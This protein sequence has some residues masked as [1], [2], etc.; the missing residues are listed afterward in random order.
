MAR[1]GLWS[2]IVASQGQLLRPEATQKKKQIARRTI[3][4]LVH[5]VGVY[6][7]R[8]R[9]CWHELT[10]T[11][12]SDMAAGLWIVGAL[13]F[14]IG[15]VEVPPFGDGHVRFAQSSMTAIAHRCLIDGIENFRS[16]RN[17][18]W[19]SKA[20]IRFGEKRQR[21]FR[22]Q[23]LT[24]GFP[25]YRF[26]ACAIVAGET[27]A[28]LSELE[29]SVGARHKDHAISEAD[30]C[31]K[32]Q[33]PDQAGNCHRGEAAEGKLRGRLSS[34][35]PSMFFLKPIGSFGPRRRTEYPD[36]RNQLRA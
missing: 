10:K 34:G 26:P 5:V 24:F 8:R 9:C 31:A 23:S 15:T 12:R 36:A 21:V 29:G 27:V 2:S 13:D 18:P 11:D 6:A 1:N 19:R 4:V 16:C 25:D 14:D 7:E 30:I 22:D 20:G 33:S 3:E 17:C 28:L 32:C 35:F